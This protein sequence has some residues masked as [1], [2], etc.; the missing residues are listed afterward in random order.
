ME[1]NLIHFQWSKLDAIFFSW[2]ADERWSTRGRP[3]NF[4]SL[5]SEL[6]RVDET[7]VRQI[8]IRDKF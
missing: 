6:S 1:T 4:W 8:R 3:C 7:V 5:W 2:L